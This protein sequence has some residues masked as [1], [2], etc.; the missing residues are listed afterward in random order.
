MGPPLPDSTFFIT[1]VSG[2]P[3]SGTTGMESVSEAF[4]LL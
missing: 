2:S 3:A 4:F 1:C